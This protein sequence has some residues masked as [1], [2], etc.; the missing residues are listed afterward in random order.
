MIEVQIAMT[1]ANPAP[2]NPFKEQFF[3]RDRELVRK[4]ANRFKSSRRNCFG[5]EGLDLREIFVRADLQF[6]G[7]SPLFDL[8]RR[9]FRFVKATETRDHPVNLGFAY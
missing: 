8:G 6:F 2:L 4:M 5:N 1:I 9:S 3:V 7:R